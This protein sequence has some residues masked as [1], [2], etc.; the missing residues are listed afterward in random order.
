[1]S[2]ET[3]P[4]QNDAGRIMGKALAS[5]ARRHTYCLI[6]GSDNAKIG[7][8]VAVKLGER[9]FLATAAHVIEDD[10]ANVQ[11]ILQNQVAVAVSNF[12]GRHYD[13]SADVGLLEVSASDAHQFSFLEH[14]HLLETIEEQQQLPVIVVGFAGQFCGGAVETDLT[15]DTLL[16]MRFC[17]TLSYH[18]V[19]LPKSGWPPDGLPDENCVCQML[20]EGRD[21]LVDF[22]YRQEVQPFTP[23][24]C[25]GDN[26]TVECAS[27]DPHGI[28]GGG[29]WLAQV[30]EGP[31]RVSRP[32]ARLIGLQIGWHRTE[33]VLRG[34]RIGAWL[35]LVREKYP[36]LEDTI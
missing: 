33:N 5:Q 13:L 6:H 19:V 25:G 20:T 10:T 8:A 16:Q 32:D 23:R 22:Q 12:V 1:M 24:S 31:E 17:N 34:V 36:D 29:I 35:D 28:S 4:S 7:T 14:T 2:Q 27:L 26:P 18:T 9:Y 21:M 11:A 30:T 3:M 15:P